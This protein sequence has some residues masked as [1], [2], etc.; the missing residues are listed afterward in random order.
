MTL[1]DSV[2]KFLINSL[3]TRISD[4]Y[5]IDKLELVNFISQIECST[6]NDIEQEIKNPIIES[7]TNDIEQEIKNPIHGCIYYMKKK[8]QVCGNEIKSKLQTH[9]TKHARYDIDKSKSRS[10][11]NHGIS[12]SNEDTRATELDISLIND[13]ESGLGNLNNTKTKICGKTKRLNNE[14]YNINKTKSNINISDTTK[15]INHQSRSKLNNSISETNDSN[16]EDTKATELDIKPSLITDEESGLGNF[17]NTKTKIFG[18]TKRLNN[19]IYN[20]NK[21]KS[22]INISEYTKM[23]NHQSTDIISNLE[24]INDTNDQYTKVIN[25]QSTDIISNLE[26]INDSED[27]DLVDIVKSGLLNMRIEHEQSK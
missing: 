4:R 16:D 7:L 9:C 14:I 12:D 23:I 6:I 17:N 27:S 19:E 11:L 26:N 10:K 18:K 3:A 1:L 25:H 24:N 5:N 13:E 22:N 21:T 8:K 20:T 2:F 15:V